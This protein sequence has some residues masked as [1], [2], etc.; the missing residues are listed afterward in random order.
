MIRPNQI[1]EIQKP[2]NS[3]DQFGKIGQTAAELGGGGGCTMRLCDQCHIVHIVPFRTPLAADAQYCTNN[4]HAVVDE[5]T[6]RAVT[7]TIAPSMIPSVLLSDPVHSVCNCAL[8]VVPDQCRWAASQGEC[9]L[10]NRGR[11]LSATRGPMF[12]LIAPEDPRL[13]LAPTGRGGMAWGCN[14]PKSSWA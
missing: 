8:K 13:V 7:M 12:P 11:G 5:A 2:N 1:G 9:V 3:A 10:A 6:L 4:C 14:P